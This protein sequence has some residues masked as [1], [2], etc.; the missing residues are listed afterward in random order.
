MTAMTLEHR[1]PSLTR[2]ERVILAN[3]SEDATLEQIARR[4]YVTRNTVKTQVRSVY[5]K[6]G[7]SSRAEAIAKAHEYQ[8]AD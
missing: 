6:L 2:R 8:L 5:R 4:L 7:V 1:V 3:L